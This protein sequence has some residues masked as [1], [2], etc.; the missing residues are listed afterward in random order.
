MKNLTILARFQH[1]KNF[2]NYNVRLKI[3]LGYTSF[4]TAF[5]TSSITIAGR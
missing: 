1:L 3:E 5:S 2:F 4:I